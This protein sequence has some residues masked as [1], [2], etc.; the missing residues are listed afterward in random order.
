MNIIKTIKK[1]TTKNIIFRSVAVAT[2]LAM[3]LSLAGFGGGY[4]R[5]REKVLRLHIL[6]NSDSA[7]DQ[8]LKLKV[9]DAVLLK[10]SEIFSG[11]S[12]EQEAVIAAKENM[13]VITAEAE[14]VVKEN[15]YNYE[16]NV[17]VC[18]T[19]FEERT[20]EDF[21]LPAG[22]YEAVKIIIGGGEGHNWWC[23]MF[24]SV[25]LPSAGND[26]NSLSDVLNEKET[27]MCENP[28][29]YVAKFKIVELFQRCRTELQKVL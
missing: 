7:A 8:N 19:W 15:G 5:I 24:P 28:K 2:V 11:C 12:N 14:R 22:S 9:R 27:D 17:S 6:A 21:T 4:D 20:Y 29:R 23:V 16:V 25:C 3:A 1:Y 18:D 10:T 13:S 26:G